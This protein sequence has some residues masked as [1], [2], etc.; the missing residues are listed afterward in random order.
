MIGQASLVLREIIISKLWLDPIL[1]IDKLLAI[2]QAGGSHGA[3]QCAPF[4]FYL[5]LLMGN[6]N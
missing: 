5:H 3:S 4:F 1:H 2:F 6:K